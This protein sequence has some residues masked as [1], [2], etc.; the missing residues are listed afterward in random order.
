MS[1]ILACSDCGGESFSWMLKQVQFGSVHE[2]DSGKRD[3]EGMKLG[4]V[5]DSDIHEAGPWCTE[6]DEHKDIDSLVVTDEDDE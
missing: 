4:P 1:E 6:C 2:F 5:V 3:G